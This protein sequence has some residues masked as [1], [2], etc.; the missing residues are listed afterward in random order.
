[1]RSFYSLAVALAFALP[2]FATGWAK[3]IPATILILSLSIYRYGSEALNKLGLRIPPLQAPYIG[4]LLL[5]TYALSYFIGSLIA[6]GQGLWVDRKAV[7]L[8]WVLF[9][10]FQALNEEMIFRGL[11]LRWFSGRMDRLKASLLSALVFALAHAI[12]YPFTQGGALE[13]PALFSLFLM[14][15]ATNQLF[16]H[17]GHIGFSFAI[18]AGWNLFQYGGTRFLDPLTNLPV[19]EAVLFNTVVGNPLVVLCS[20]ALWLV[21]MGISLRRRAEA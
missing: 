5:A 15:M 7:H 8:G 3:F 16:F 21:T 10:L 20:G 14:A 2:Y 17:F 11:L 9:P 6:E 19:T 12:F 1:M 13:A 4:I 18:H